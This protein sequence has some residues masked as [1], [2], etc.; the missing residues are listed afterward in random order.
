MGGRDLAVGVVLASL[1]VGCAPGGGIAAPSTRPSASGPAITETV[2]QSG[3]V[4]PWEVAVAPDGRMFVTERPGTISV[5]ESTAPMAKRITSAQVSGVRAMGEAG[6]LGLALDPDF[7]RNEF[8][9][10]CASRLDQ[11]EW[12]NEVLRYRASASALAVDTT[13]LRAGIVASGLHD[14]CRMHFGPDGKLWIATG[15]GGVPAR[16]QDATSLNGKVLR[17]NADGSVPGDNPTLK[18]QSAPSAVYALGLRNPGGLAFDPKTGSCFVVDAGDQMQD[19]IDEVSAGANFGWPTVVGPNGSSR[20]FVDPVWSSGAAT[21][22]VAG[23]AFLSGPDW[24][25]W[26]DSLVVTTLK[27][28]DLRRFTVDDAHAI[29]HEVLLDQKYGRLRAVTAAPDGSLLVTTST[30]S[31]DQI[32]RIMPAR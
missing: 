8:I 9:Y 7:P 22:A 4:V 29:Q 25:A 20:G 13:I 32:I 26:S 21:I 27:E 10:V 5:F 3:L 11:G 14:G 23:A 30:G 1:A 15:D 12:R 31:G 17:I 19:E 18:G 28:Q 24:G 2:I 16:A 6:L